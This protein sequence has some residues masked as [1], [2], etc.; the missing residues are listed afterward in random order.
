MTCRPLCK[1]WTSELWM[2]VWKRWR[3]LFSFLMPGLSRIK[4]LE[5]LGR[6]IFSWVRC[7]CKHC[8]RLMVLPWQTSS[9]HLLSE[10]TYFPTHRI[11][12]S[13]KSCIFTFLAYVS[14]C[15]TILCLLSNHP[16]WFLLSDWPQ[17]IDDI[18]SAP[19]KQAWSQ[20]QLNIFL[21]IFLPSSSFP[22]PLS[23]RRNS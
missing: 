11:A 8:S 18:A 23:W 13:P 6:V 16:I 19:K 2:R 21:T 9:E 20:G 7:Y 15:D 1:V 4:V 17:V 5:I 10:C 12:G 22:L 3:L 14:N